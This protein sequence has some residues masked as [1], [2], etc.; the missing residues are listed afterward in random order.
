MCGVSRGGGEGEEEGEGLRWGE[1][2][3]GRGWEV[4][5]LKGLRERRG[6]GRVGREGKVEGGR[7]KRE[8]D[9]RA[10]GE[11]GGGRGRGEGKQG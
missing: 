3:D 6:E 4:E 11:G 8:R 9:E 7:G 2:K 1:G 5:G 10:E